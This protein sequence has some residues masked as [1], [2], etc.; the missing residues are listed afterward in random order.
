LIKCV[1]HPLDGSFYSHRHLIN[2]AVNEQP[3]TSETPIDI[4]VPIR[5]PDDHA[6]LFE[7]PH[8]PIADTKCVCELGLMGQFLSVPHGHLRNWKY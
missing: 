1:V 8:P 2:I 4:V 5:T 6:L 7:L 3:I